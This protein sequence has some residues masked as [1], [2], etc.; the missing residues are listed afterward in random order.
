MK[1]HMRVSNCMS[2]YLIHDHIRCLDARL[3]EFSS[4]YPNSKPISI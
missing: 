1:S 3:C 2:D 4:K